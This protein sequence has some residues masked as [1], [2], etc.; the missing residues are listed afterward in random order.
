MLVTQPGFAAAAA[1]AVTNGPPDRLP[2]APAGPERG[3][4]RPPWS[5]GA[6]V[7]YE[8][9]PYR[10]ADDRVWGF[11]LITYR[12]QRFY[13]LGPRAGYYLVRDG[14]FRL[15][16]LGAIRFRSFEPD[17][18]P[19]LAGM[20]SRRET[21]DAGARLQWI[22]EGKA[23]IG[24]QVVSD[25]LD[26]HGGQEAGA[27]ISRRFP[28]GTWA[29][30]PTLRLSWQTSSLSDYYYGVEDAEATD[31][32]P[33]FSPGDTWRAVG[34]L[35]ISTRRFAPWVLS[36]TAQMEYLTPDLKDSPIVERH[37]LFQAFLG[38]SYSF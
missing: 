5:V 20:G 33:A 13:I 3:G 7:V 38:L 15:S 18:S 30:Q 8:Q 6:A 25:T 22:H 21:L 34:S 27:D 28:F 23:D 2:S 10:G 35:R 36:G 11:P 26:R 14:D 4:G 19:Y 31:Q 1:S 17:D 12:G 29:V 37:V 16:L 9:Q 32:R 24:L